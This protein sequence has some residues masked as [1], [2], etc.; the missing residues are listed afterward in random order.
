MS[1]EVAEARATGRPIVALESTII[2][3]GMPWPRN[4]ETAKAVE[5]AIREEGAVPATIAILDGTVHAGL[6]QDELEHLARARE[7]AKLSRADLAVCMAQGGTGATT[8]AATMIVAHLAGIEVFATGGIG[9]VHRGAEESFD[10]S[11]D[12][13]ELAQTPVTVIAAG[14]KAILD[15]SK[16]LEVLETLGVPVIGFGQDAFPAFWSRDAGLRAPLRLDTARKIASAHAL[17]ANLGLSGGQLIANPIP[18][19]HEIAAET[20]LPLIETATRE[21]AERGITGKAVT[22]F[23][24]QRLFELTDGASLEAN[25]ALVLSNARLG[26]RIACELSALRNSGEGKV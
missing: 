26:A 13:Q 1:P 25:I 15:L 5:A 18:V 2:T 12:L 4:F 7:V 19:A 22:P 9:G 20:L 24:L 17:R 8:V 3:H 21:A 10:I 23:L 11:A 6:S 16:T 14:A